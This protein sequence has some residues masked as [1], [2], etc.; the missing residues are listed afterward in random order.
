[1]KKIILLTILIGIIIVPNVNAFNVITHCYVSSQMFDIWQYYDP[2]FYRDLTNPADAISYL[3]KKYYY[4]GL[5]MPDMLDATGQKWSINTLIAVN[6]FD[7]NL[8]KM[9]ALDITPLEENILVLL[10]D[11]RKLIRF[12][13]SYIKSRGK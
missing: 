8:S 13:S 10:G 9:S 1:M 12:S 3:V 11:E 7:F 6:T 2:Q 4:I 5:T